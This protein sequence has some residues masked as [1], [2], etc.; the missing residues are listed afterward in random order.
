MPSR[1]HSSSSR[2]MPTRGPN[3]PR[4]SERAS[5]APPAIQTETPSQSK[6]RQTVGWSIAPPGKRRAA[7]AG[8]A[9]RACVRSLAERRR[10]DARLRRD[11]RDELLLRA[12][13]GHDREAAQL[14][15]VALRR[16][17]D[18]ADRQG[19]VLEL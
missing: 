14:R 5:V 18:V 9:A 16:P 6:L 17:G 1:R 13:E 3:S 10:Q 4:D 8:P 19:L 11:L 12:D 7:G 2:G 15:D